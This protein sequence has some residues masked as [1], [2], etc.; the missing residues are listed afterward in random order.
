MWRSVLATVLVYGYGYPAFDGYRPGSLDQ[1]LQIFHAE[2]Q[3]AAV[4]GIVALQG[5]DQQRALGYVRVFT[6]Q[7]E[8]EVKG[9]GAKLPDGK[10]LDR[11]APGDKSESKAAVVRSIE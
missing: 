1:P 3:K 6:D 2:V 5:I 9:S 4:M 7:F 11:K 10:M 8:A